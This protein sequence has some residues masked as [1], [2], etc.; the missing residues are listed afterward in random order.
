M[1]TRID[2]NF[3][4][5]AFFIVYNLLKSQMRVVISESYSEKERDV[6]DGR[7]KI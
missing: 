5:H 4:P 3:F 1:Q 2:S 6:N 7:K